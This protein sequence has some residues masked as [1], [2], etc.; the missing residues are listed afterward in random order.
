M[1]YFEG[2]GRDIEDALDR[3]CR[4][5]GVS[6]S[7]LEYEVLTQRKRFLGIL[8][9]DVVLVRAWRRG[10][11][12][13]VALEFL[14]QIFSHAGMECAASFHGE[15]EDSLRITVEGEDADRLT[16]RGGELLDSFQYVLN[17]ALGRGGRQ[18]RR[19]IL[20]AGGFRARRVE[21]LKRMTVIS[22]E[23]VRTSGR[24]VV[25]SPMN[26]HD[27]RIIHL[28]LQDDREVFT[29]SLGEGP[30]KKIVI[31]SKETQRDSESTRRKE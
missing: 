17:K 29:R 19:V 13:Q 22:A 3:I 21:E 28:Q 6:K 11:E 30:F 25:L 24:S 15:E 12:P 7:D 16:D 4:E 27:R 20:D 23:Q 18:H 1:E 26:A 9:R 2:E 5:K 8:G 31:A 14:T 10:D